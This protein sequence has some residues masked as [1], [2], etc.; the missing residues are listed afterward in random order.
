MMQVCARKFA[1]VC[2]VFLY[3][4]IWRT[5]LVSGDSGYRGYGRKNWHHDIVFVV[6]IVYNAFEK[7]IIVEAPIFVDIYA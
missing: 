2:K 3:I 6:H 5:G 1:K 4:Q 7:E